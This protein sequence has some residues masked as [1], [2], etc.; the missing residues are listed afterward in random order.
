MS[1]LHAHGVHAGQPS[2]CVCEIDVCGHWLDD[3]ENLPMWAGGKMV[4]I[5]GDGVDELVAKKF[6]LPKA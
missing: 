5:V 2:H 4:I 1:G 6:S 3:K